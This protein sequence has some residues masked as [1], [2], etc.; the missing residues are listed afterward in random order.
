MPQRD[1][2]RTASELAAV[3]CVLGQMLQVF[4]SSAGELSPAA[5]AEYA[6]PYLEQVKRLCV[7]SSPT[8]HQAQSVSG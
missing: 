7:V 4:E 2:A 8:L 6:L 5:F 3:V 1:R